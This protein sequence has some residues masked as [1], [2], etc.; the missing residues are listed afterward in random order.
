MP[1]LKRAAPK[2]R[3][4]SIKFRPKYAGRMAKDL[5]Q[6]AARTLLILSVAAG[7]VGG[8]FAA[9]YVW[10]HNERLKIRDVIVQGDIP[11]GLEK[12]LPFE[13][14]RNLILVRPAQAQRAILAAFPE[15]R[16][17]SVRRTWSRNV[18]VTGHYRTPAAW[19]EQN[20]KTHFLDSNGVAFTLPAD[21]VDTAH[22]PELQCAD[23][24]D[25][26]LLLDCLARWA[27]RYSSF[28]SQIVK[29]ETDTIHRLQVKLADGTVVEWGVVNADALDVRTQHVMR[30]MEKFHPAKTP[31][32][33]LFV[34][35]DRLV[36]DSNWE[37]ATLTAEGK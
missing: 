1:A 34:T 6:R 11:A 9:Q 19:F 12:S 18:I 35:D 7:V 17:V 33:L 2:R 36:M 25:R 29:C 22:L 10:S 4:Q 24:T 37:Q 30:V 13:R 28:A 23:E 27:S 8:A 31:A 16:S 21:T 32:R 20:G 15:L 3:K 26:A 14:G 5:G